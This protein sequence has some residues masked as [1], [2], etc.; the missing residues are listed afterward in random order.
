MITI[1][2]LLVKAIFLTHP[3]YEVNMMTSD[4]TVHPDHPGSLVVTLDNATIATIIP[5]ICVAL[6]LGIRTPPW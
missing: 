6:I 1:L 3:I 4:Y 2:L 5:G